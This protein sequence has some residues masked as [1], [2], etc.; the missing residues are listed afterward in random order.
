MSARDDL[1]ALFDR[2]GVAHT[3]LEHP[4]VFRVGEGDDVKATLPENAA[5]LDKVFGAP[6]ETGCKM[7]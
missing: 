1:F 5:D 2:L 3:T 4:A 7:A 6:E